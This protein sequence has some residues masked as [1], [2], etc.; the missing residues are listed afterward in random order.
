MTRPSPRT[1]VLRRV[2]VV[3][4]LGASLAAVL[5]LG[6]QLAS[7]V[8]DPHLRSDGASLGGGA[9]KAGPGELPAPDCE[10][11]SNDCVP[12]PGCAVDEGACGS[13][14]TCMPLRDQKAS[15][16]KDLRIRRLNITAPDALSQEFIQRTVVTLNIDLDA[17]KCGEVGKGLFSW[18]L[19]VDREKNELVTGGAPPPKD[20][21]GQGFCFARYDANGIGIEPATFPIAF[22][23]NTFKTT[24][25]KKL[26]VPVFLSDDLA[27]SI[28]LPLTDVVVS[29]V[30]L[31]DEGNCVGSF[32]KAGLRAD[33]T[34]D[35]SSCPKWRTAGALGGYM[36]LEEADAVIIRDLGRSLCVVLSKGSPGP[37]GK[38]NRGP[39]GKIAFKGD[40][41]STT[42]SAQGC[43]D[44]VWLAATFAASGASIFDGAGV[45]GCSGASTRDGGA[46]ATADT[47]ADTGAD[48]ATDAGT[49]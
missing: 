20:P 2:F 11:S 7:C 25:K 46:D 13:M 23:G 35:P 32:Q 18:L 16:Q 40:Y 42:N 38:C 22:E 19:R 17:K 4:G 6:S 41:C 31:S 14:G 12:E 39:D 44:S 9:C 5:A 1:S 45:P 15:K 48:G 49:D 3:A 33:C 10:S 24:E 28:V 29:G 36:T 47:G 34:E 30:T 43:Q 27:S 26:N 21:L 8:D 37:G